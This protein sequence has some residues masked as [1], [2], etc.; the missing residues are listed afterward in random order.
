MPKVI[1][2]KFQEKQDKWKLN[3]NT[4][5]FSASDVDSMETAISEIIPLLNKKL[6]SP[7]AFSKSLSFAILNGFEAMAKTDEIGAYTKAYARRL[8][9][10]LN[11]AIKEIK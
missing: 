10:Y 2:Y 9:Q 5:S 11:V 6:M 1:K 8:V 4:I 3:E 7:N